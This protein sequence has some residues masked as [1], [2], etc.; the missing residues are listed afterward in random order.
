MPSWR[1]VRKTRRATSPRLATSSI[2]MGVV[3]TAL[4]L[5]RLHP[6]HAE[7]PPALDRVGV[8]GG[9]A[10]AEDVAGVAGIDDAVVVEPGREVQRQRLR[11]D[12]VLGGP[13]ALG[14]LGLVDLP[15][16]GGRR[17]A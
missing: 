12:L 9:E 17:L 5:R 14:V 8:D 6:E 4:V 7:A 11:F 1:Q 10:H 15:A 3:V 16:G 13:A 2:R